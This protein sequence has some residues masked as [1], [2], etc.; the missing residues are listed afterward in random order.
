L[1]SDKIIKTQSLTRIN[2]ILDYINGFS[3]FDDQI[4]IIKQYPKTKIKENAYISNLVKDMKFAFYFNLDIVANKTVITLRG[5]EQEVLD[6]IDQIN[7]Y[8][9]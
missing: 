6:I 4:L 7:H 5:N 8:L 2:E 3:Q 1:S 9:K